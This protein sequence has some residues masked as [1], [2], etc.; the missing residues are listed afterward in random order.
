VGASS[1]RTTR[2]VRVGCALKTGVVERQHREKRSSF[3]NRIT[4]IQELPG[5]TLDRVVEWVE[6]IPSKLAFFFTDGSYLVVVPEIDYE[7]GPLFYY[8]TKLNMRDKHSLTVVSDEK[9]KQWKQAEEGKNQR[10]QERE[11]RRQYEQLKA[12]FEKEAP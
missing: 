6:D 11:E 5:K 9:Y 1:T 3:M 8:N 4:N 12:K 7:E 10:D 2:T